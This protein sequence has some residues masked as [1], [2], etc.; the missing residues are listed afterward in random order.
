MIIFQIFL[1]MLRYKNYNQSYFN[2]SINELIVIFV[3][4]ILLNSYLIYEEI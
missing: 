1:H 3:N 4:R 2:E